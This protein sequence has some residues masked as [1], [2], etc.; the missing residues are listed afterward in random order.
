MPSG[1]TLAFGTSTRSFAFKQLAPGLNVNV[2]VRNPWFGFENDSDCE[3]L[4]YTIRASQSPFSIE[5]QCNSG[6][7]FID[8]G[9][10]GNL[11]V[12]PTTF[13]VTDKVIPHTN[14]GAFLVNVDFHGSVSHWRAQ[15]FVTR[16]N[17]GTPVVLPSRSNIA[18]FGGKILKWSV[19]RTASPVTDTIV[20]E[21]WNANSGQFDPWNVQ[22]LPPG[23]EGDSDIPVLYYSSLYTDT[24]QPVF[25][26]RA[27]SGH[28][29][30]FFPFDSKGAFYIRLDTG[31]ISVL[32]PDLLDR[33][34]GALGFHIGGNTK[35]FP[36]LFDHFP[37]D[38]ID[39]ASNRSNV[40]SFRFGSGYAIDT[41]LVTILGRFTQEPPGYPL[42]RI[43]AFD[44]PRFL[45]DF[46]GG[47]V[48]TWDAHC[49]TPGFENCNV[50]NGVP[51]C[52]TAS[53]VP[54]PAG[55]L[56]GEKITFSPLVFGTGAAA[57]SGSQSGTGSYSPDC[58]FG[59]CSAS[60]SFSM[61]DSWFSAPVKRLSDSIDDLL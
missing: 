52:S 18:F 57:G 38:S 8:P 21:V 54:D 2:R 1:W 27:D 36:E 39:T 13:S 48:R 24:E 49:M 37:I 3:N 58:P 9:W 6:D 12:A 11:D 5:N 51:T 29:Y 31:E 47:T 35:A 23:F 15:Y 43:L 30:R 42:R 4:G 56:C 17:D 10:L 32:D 50:L 20:T 19:N 61:F 7:V 25:E 14:S 40:L 16:K 53:G 46:G 26:W 44:N 45:F 28:Y 59:N 41:P 22:P 33:V 60:G 34:V 55:N